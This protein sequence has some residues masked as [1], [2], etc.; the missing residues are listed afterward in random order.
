MPA[1]RITSP[2]KAMSQTHSRYNL[3]VVSATAM[4]VIEFPKPKAKR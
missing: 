1:A 2:S 3:C 4:L